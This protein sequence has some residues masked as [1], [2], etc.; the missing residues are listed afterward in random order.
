M[1]AQAMDSI[2]NST[3]K[4][5]FLMKKLLILSIALISIFHVTHGEPIDD[6][7]GAL[8]NIA[9]EKHSFKQE[10]PQKI[11]PVI[12]EITKKPITIV[13][14]VPAE[15]DLKPP[16]TNEIQEEFNNTILLNDYEKVKFLLEKT[17]NMNL[18]KV[19]ED[20]GGVT[21]S[22]LYVAITNDNVKIVEL[23]LKYNPNLAVVLRDP[24]GTTKAALHAAITKGNKE[25]VKLLLAQDPAPNLET[26][27]TYPD[28]YVWSALYAA[29]QNDNEEIVKLLL[30]KK[31]NLTSV[32][33]LKAVPI[34]SAE[35]AAK[36]KPAILKLIK[37]AIK[38][39]VKASTSK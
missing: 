11:E 15:T 6:L 39:R 8:K 33:Q 29:I 25:I 16:K 14:P 28:G 7:A 23:L 18:E 13:Q 31:P 5:E 1:P 35:D 30:D 9:S 12:T 34:M 4:K 21:S 22:A 20:E 24:D 19:F 38:E 17:P 3:N 37:D 2:E 26:V 27:V 32:V 36:G 10:Q